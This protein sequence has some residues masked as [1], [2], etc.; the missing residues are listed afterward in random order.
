MSYDSTLLTLLQNEPRTKR[1][2]SK[3]RAPRFD[4]LLPRL[5]RPGLAVVALLCVTF[6][7]ASCFPLHH[8]DLW[9]HLSFGR[10]IAQQGLLPTADPFRPFD[11]VAS[12]TNIP[13]LAQLAGYAAYKL[14]GASALLLTQAS[15][16]TALCAA[17]IAAAR[18]R[19][20]STSWA[21]AAASIALLLA[22]PVLGV[23]RPQLLGML[24]LA[25][26]LCGLPRLKTH[27]HPL[28]W[29]PA[30]FAL[31]VNVHGSF[32]LG[33]LLVAG[34][35]LGLSIEARRADVSWARVMHYR[36][37]RRPWI[38]LGLAWAACCLN[39][40]GFNIYAQVLSF[41][42]QPNL[43]EITEWQPTV[44]AS[45][46]G[47][48]FYASC[49]TTALL[50][51]ISP[52]RIRT[53]EVL[54]GLAFGLLALSAMRM[55]AWWALVWPWIVVPHAAA[56]WGSLNYGQPRS[57][58][59]SSISTRYSFSAM[60]LVFATLVWSPATHGLLSGRT[61]VEGTIV[62]RGTPLPLA[63]A[64]DELGVEG[65]LLAPFEWSDYL[66][67]RRG[68]SIEPLVYCHV[69]LAGAEVWQ[70][71][72]RLL[73]G[74]EQLVSLVDRYALLWLVVDCQQPP[75]LLARLIEEPRARL[76]YQDRRALVFEWLPTFRQ[77]DEILVDESQHPSVP[78]T[79]AV[80]KKQPL[81]P[82]EIGI[83]S[84]DQ[85]R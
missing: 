38:V 84:R 14:G 46:S 21:V 62:S 51:R 23:L 50:L 30:L 10:W 47:T 55:T 49:L 57:A 58:L 72:Q 20:V 64:L 33:L 6:L 59:G 68:S 77:R 52:R 48:L 18:G 45:L 1:R 5:S 80:E 34:W 75:T 9:G 53:E 60:A 63:D 22:L 12:Y 31:W 69:H 40:T 8:T 56:A 11:F 70:D 29:L 24:L 32:S 41:S 36:T 76:M 3:P 17:M 4:R 37:V 39:P 81:A 78:M 61:P 35:A 54:V 79:G 65:R 26:V 19:G 83:E 66:L 16:V 42:A 71:Y 15:L 67:W 43:G 74:D 82:T 2:A 28:V 44:L 85:R 7:A 27:R 25:L 73:R 13:W